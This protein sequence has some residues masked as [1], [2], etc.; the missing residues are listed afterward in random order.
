M[1][2]TLH[3]SDLDNFTGTERWFRHGLNRKITYTEGVQHVA[4]TG[5]A[6]WLIDEIALIQP[7]DAA[8]RGEA[9]QVWTL[10]VHGD[11]SATLTCDDGDGHIV[12]TKVIEYTDFPL[13]EISFYCTDN[14]IMLPSEY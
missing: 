7:Y 9:F 10:R 12:Y 4:E 2:K 8:V 13:D 6:Y 1:T 14:V 11:R 5:G 3:K